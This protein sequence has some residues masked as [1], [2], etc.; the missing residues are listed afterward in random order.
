MG[1]CTNAG[2]GNSRNYNHSESA[3]YDCCYGWIWEGGKGAAGFPES[4]VGDVIICEADLASGKL[5]W[6]R[7]GKTFKE[8]DVP[9]QMKDKT[10]YFSIIMCDDRDEVLVSL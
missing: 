10:V 6:H 1:F 4:V 2:L 5:R 8:C 7:N 9:A 3:Y